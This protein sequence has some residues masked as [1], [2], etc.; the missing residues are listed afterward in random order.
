MERQPVTES[1]TE[2]VPITAEE[3]AELDAEAAQQS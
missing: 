2:P 3:V 1:V